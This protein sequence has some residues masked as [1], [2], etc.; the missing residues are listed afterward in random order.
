[1]TEEDVLFIVHVYSAYTT[2]NY[3]VTHSSFIMHC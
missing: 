3:K 1:M 2:A